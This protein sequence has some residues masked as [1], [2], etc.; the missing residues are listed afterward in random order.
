MHRR[1]VAMGVGNILVEIAHIHPWLIGVAIH[2]ITGVCQAVLEVVDKVRAPQTGVADSKS[3]REIQPGGFRRPAREKGGVTGV[4]VNASPTEE[5]GVTA[6]LRDL[7]VDSA[8]VPVIA[9]RRGCGKAVG[10]E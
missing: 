10:S 3:S 1:S 9:L 5:E 2:P 8:D 6:I 4:V 7:V